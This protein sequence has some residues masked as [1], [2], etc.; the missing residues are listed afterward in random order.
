M[1]SSLS[2]S[3]L[4]TE[5][6]AEFRTLDLKTEQQKKSLDDLL[7]LLSGELETAP[8]TGEITEFEQQGQDLLSQLMSGAS[9][10]LASVRDASQFDQAGIDELFRTTIRDPLVEDVRENI[11]PEIS[12][13]FG[14][15][16]FSSERVGQEGRAIDTL[17]RTLAGE[18]NKLVQGERNRQLQALGLIPQFT[19]GAADVGRSTDVQRTAD[20]EADRKRK[21]L[22]QLL[23]G[24]TGQETFENIGIVTPGKEGGLTS[25]LGGL[26]QGLGGAA[27]ACWVAEV[28]YGYNS[29]ITYTIRSYVQRHME[30]N[31]TLG[32]FFRKYSQDCKIWAKGLIQGILPW[33]D[34]KSIWDDLYRLALTEQ[35]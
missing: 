35:E 2:E 17:V 15:Q 1:A 16:F 21:E 23:L 24:G 34:M 6:S 32:I 29:D 13:R 14:S 28:L 7:K 27:A 18:K 11:I 8:T 20:T 10:D 30:D 33:N 26:G 5:S 19:A 22:M 25:F 3:I 31:T 4:G 9:G 12:A